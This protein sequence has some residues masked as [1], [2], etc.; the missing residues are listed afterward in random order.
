MKTL[1]DHEIH[2]R[3][4]RDG[5]HK[6]TCPKCSHTRK[7][8][9]DTCLS[10]K[11]DG[12]SAIYNCHHCGWSGAVGQPREEPR[13]V[14]HRPSYAVKT[15]ILSEKVE[16]FFEGRNISRATLIK[17]RIG[18]GRRW[19]PKAG[20]EVDVIEFPYLRDGEIVNVKYR[21][22]DKDFMQEKDAEKIL[23][24]MD[25]IP[26]GTDTL[27][28]VEGEMDKLA[29]NEAG[30]WNVVSVPDGAPKEVREDGGGKKFEYV[31]NCFDFLQ[32][33]ASV[34]LA[35]DNDG[36]GGALREELARRIGKE[37][38]L[39]VKF[40]A[41]CKDANDVL[42]KFGNVGVEIL[43]GGAEP[44]PIAGLYRIAD[45]WD[46]VL[47]FYHDGYDQGA[48]TG[49][50][51]VDALYKI[52]PGLLSIVTG[53]PGSGKS[54]FVDAICM[55]LAMEKDWRI[56][57][58]SLENRR[59]VHVLKLIKKYLGK[60]ARKEFCTLAELEQ[61]RADIQELFSFI[62]PDQKEGTIEWALD[63]ARI[64]VKRYGINGLVLDPY[65]RF[66]NNKPPTMPGTDWIASQIAMVQAFAQ[67]CGVH[68]WFI[69]HP[70]KMESTKDAPGLYDISGSA[71]W[72]NMTDFGITV[73][74]PFDETTGERSPL[75]EI[76]IKKVRFDFM[77]REGV[78]S[79]LYDQNS[80]RYKSARF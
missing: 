7:N 52:N 16:K 45:F 60:P 61:A 30:F 27:I 38:C 78:T 39:R 73:H 47:K 31:E 5:D 19:M 44:F 26:D 46:E 18:H 22:P 2:V 13:R 20:K 79:L 32:S 69:A 10:V 57:F 33:F 54:E 75:T 1:T 59:D 21:G 56:G 25:D 71:H 6:T 70:A 62:I 41:E 9:R 67:E 77:G 14:Y 4:K 12:D 24:G 80:G 72:F 48:S 65:N 76:H 36:P 15:E 51:N 42:K 43:I 3:S 34:I 28:I 49:F 40:P 11:I 50:S 8:K 63:R 66:F 55:N 68:V 53:V 58:C 64:A 23:F 74:R 35:T 29:C 17:N 37:K